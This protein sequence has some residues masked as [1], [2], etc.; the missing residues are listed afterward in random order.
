M[1]YLP[2]HEAFGEIKVVNVY[3][4]Y[5][6]PRTFVSIT[7]KQGYVF[8][9]WIDETETFDSWY[10]VCISEEQLGRL[11][12][13]LIQLRDLFKGNKVF[14]VDTPYDC[15]IQSTVN[16]IQNEQLDSEAL[17]PKGFALRKVGY[18]EYC[19]DKF[20][21]ESFFCTES[22]H[23]IRINNPRSKKPIAWDAIESIFGI[24]EKI[25][26]EL[27]ESF[28]NLADD[29]FITPGPAEVGSYK[30]N[31]ESSHNDIALE[32]ARRLFVGL[33][34]ANGQ[35]NRLEA[36][37]FDLSLV[38]ELLSSLSEYNL[39]FEV[40]DSSGN[41]IEDLDYKDLSDSIQT[42]FEYNQEKVPS[43]LV[44]QANDISRIITYIKSKSR[45]I[46]FTSESEGIAPRQITYYTTASK[47]LGFVDNG[48]LTPIG[49]RLSET[50]SVQTQYEILLD[51][52]ETSRC[53]WAWMKYCNVNS[54]LKL[55]PSS[56]VEFLKQRSTGLSDSTLLR[57]ASTLRK[58]PELFRDKL[59]STDH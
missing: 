2:K 57:R 7:E 33:K 34:A 30:I 55:E 26:N 53:G 13:G 32:S 36:L 25:H 11:E 56:A 20:S 50:D 58:W 16:Q 47:M 37:S 10:Y 22:S 8:S 15:E 44:P 4:H 29:I 41:V 38:E 18:N 28:D 6:V 21:E 3:S 59:T 24:W 51:R 48:L 23:Q 31:F 46:P 40:R 14:Q 12:A 27:L 9:F 49:W 35:I 39:Q 17:P 54:A 52:F 43:S 19:V 5:D 45:G 42:I 1:H